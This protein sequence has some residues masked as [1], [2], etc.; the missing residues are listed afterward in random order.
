VDDGWLRIEFLGIVEQPA[1]AAIVIE[2]P[3]ATRKVNCG[4]AAYQDY[5]ADWAPEVRPPRAGLPTEDFY[6]DWGTAEFGASAGAKA[7]EI[8]ARVDGRLPRPVSWFGGPGGLSSDARPWVEA[9]KDYAFVNEFAALRP[10]VRGAGALERFDY[11]SNQLAYLRA[12]GKLSCAIHVLNRELEELKTLS[13]TAARHA[14]AHE[15][16]LPAY[17]EVVEDIRVVYRHLLATV[18]T[19]GEMG[20]VANW[21]QHIFPLSIAPAT[22]ALSE[23][24]GEALP[25]DLILKQTYDGPVRVFLRSLRSSIAANERLT[26][27]PIVLAPTPVRALTLHWRRIGESEFAGTA[28]R[29]VARGVYRVDVTA[30]SAGDII[31][32]YLETTPE[33]GNPIRY[34]VT[35]PELNHT[36]VV[37]P[38]LD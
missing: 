32:Y 19:P 8:L 14:F 20:T 34:P 5:A 11:W 29:H 6:R 27:E 3:G 35:A 30:G 9:A 2:G 12:T 23:A 25:E 24:L 16:V 15:A 36:V 31:E 26:L 7:A 13:E 17:R 28:C 10:L 21:E 18:S 4:G 22:K 33:S 1:I 37:T 38:A